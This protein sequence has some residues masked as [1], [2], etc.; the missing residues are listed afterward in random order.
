MIFCRYLL[1]VCPLVAAVAQ[2]SSQPPRIRP[3]TVVLKVGDSEITAAQ[4]EAIVDSLPPQLREFVMGSGRKE[5]AVQMARGLALAQEG[6][7]RKLDQ[8]PEFKI[9]ST[10]RTNEIMATFAETAIAREIPEGEAAAREYYESHKSEYERVRA[11][12]L[13]IRTKGSPIP[14]RPGAK[15]LSDEEGAAKAESLR[16]KILSGSDFAAIAKAESDDAASTT[17]GGD[18]GWFK[19]G[20]MVPAFEEAAFQ[21]KPGEISKLVKTPFGYHILKLEGRE[22]EPFDQVKPSL[23]EK[24]RAENLQKALTELLDGAKINYNPGFFGLDKP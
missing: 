15:V 16:Q 18:L 7:R 1:L 21:L 20:Q 23:E 8:K 19:R 4:F 10:Y 22:W 2:T 14:P 12:H 6:Y 3:D 24:L 9:Q 17:S 13:L 5:F 11:R